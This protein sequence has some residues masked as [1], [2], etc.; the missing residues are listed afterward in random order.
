[1]IGFTSGWSVS[2]A[3]A[4]SSTGRDAEI[5]G[6]VVARAGAYLMGRRMFDEGEEP[7]GDPPPFHAPVFVVT[8]NARETLTKKGGTTFTFVTEGLESALARAREAA[9]DKDVAVAGGAN[10]IHQLIEARLLDE[11]QIHVVPVL[12][13]DGTRLFDRLRDGRIEMEPTRVVES[14]GVTHL[15]YRVVK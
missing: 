14:P 3:G 6:E 12:F 10:M 11:L 4:S 9:G 13:G 2:R 15:A 5:Q 7:W 1:V 8:H